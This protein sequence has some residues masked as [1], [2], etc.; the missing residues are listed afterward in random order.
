[1]IDWSG[2]QSHLLL[3]PR[4]PQDERDR[5]EDL[6]EAVPSLRAHVWLATSG[7]TGATR[8]V[9]LSIEAM[10]A[11]A[12]AV[13]AHL[14]VTAADVWCRVLPV[15]HVGGLAIHARAWLSN[16]RVIES[17]WNA[18][19]FARGGFTLS[20]LV[21][22]QVIDLVDGAYAAPQGV[23]AIVVGGG[24][25]APDLLE[26][27]SDLGWALLPSYGLTEAAS[28]VATAEEPGSGELRL[29]RH[30]EAR[31][32]N[33]VL[34]VRGSSLLTAYAQYDER[35]RAVLADPKEGGWFATGDRGTVA[36]RLIS[37]QGRGADFIKIGGES[38]DLVRLDG[39]LDS[40]RGTADVALYAAE[41]ARLGYVVEL[42]ATVEDASLIVRAFNAQVAPYERIRGVR[43]LSR[44]PRTPLG[45]V[46]RSELA[47]M[48]ASALGD[49]T[50]S[51]E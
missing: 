9:A 11:G 38:V 14:E 35:G 51:V 13:N 39:V 16:S 1:M 19:V 43:R 24:R 49:A 47:R 5:L 6:H 32:Q 28:Q 4:L 20:S 29:L 40:V 37:V 25:L 33:G 23:R 15:F 42:A 46:R 30:L 17:T 10:L 22:A 50:K 27:A 18:A 2:R 31:E 8:L 36:G 21:P 45:K 44:I 48:A 41:D 7:T 26:R 34:E 3:N 12:A